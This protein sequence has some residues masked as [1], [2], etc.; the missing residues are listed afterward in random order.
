MNQ[1]SFLPG[2]G[3]GKS[4]RLRQHVLSAAEQNRYRLGSLFVVSR[5]GGIGFYIQLRL[6]PTFN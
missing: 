1:I 6:G 3:R 2:I 4:N 5:G